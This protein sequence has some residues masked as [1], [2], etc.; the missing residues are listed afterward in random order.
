MSE[1]PQSPQ[2][3]FEGPAKLLTAYIDEASVYDGRGMPG[4]KSPAAK[5]TAQYGEEG[6][7]WGFET[8]QYAPEN[9]L[10]KAI[11]VP[12]H[13]LAVEGI[14]VAL[15]TGKYETKDGIDLNKANVVP[16]VQKPDMGNVVV[17]P[18]GDHNVAKT[19]AEQEQ[20]DA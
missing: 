18:D 9:E 1:T 7:G 5:Y 10:E 14:H 15:V 17:Y 13:T 16:Y 6:V 19:K 3:K 11:S 20:D 4:G 8:D 12:E 2:R